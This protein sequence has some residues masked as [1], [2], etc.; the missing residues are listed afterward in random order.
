MTAAQR[1]AINRHNARKSTGPITPEGKER[2]RQN[3]LK[4][5][6]CAA[7]LALPIENADDLQNQFDEWVA[8]YQPVGPAEFAM[9]EEIAHAQLRLRRCRRSE[10]A[11]VELQVNTA[12]RTW[13]DA[14]DDRLSA[15]QQL[16]AVDPAAA[17]RQLR[18]FGPGRRY[19]IDR[20]KRLGRWFLRDGYCG[21]TA[22]VEEAVRLLGADPKRLPAGPPVA[23]EFRVCCTGA[24]PVRDE[25]YLA[26]LLSDAAIH[27][28]Y[29]AEYGRAVPE[30]DDCRDMVRKIVTAQIEALEQEEDDWRADE[31]AEAAGACLRAQVPCDGPDTKLTLRYEAQA[32]GALHKALK[33]L[34]VLQDAR[35]AAESGEP[36]VIALADAP[37]EP[38]PSVARNEPDTPP[39]SPLSADIQTSCDSSTE[40]NPAAVTTATL[41]VEEVAGVVAVATTEIDTTIPPIVTPEMAESP[42]A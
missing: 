40:A 27:P 33:A 17:V 9:V 35:Y 34:D 14:Q 1:R 37:P 32:R 8:S 25:T 18:R 22:L 6:L 31:Q 29:H 4:H 2:A 38:L 39:E 20:W 12:Y 21:T 19:M 15:L 16:L 23:Y 28:E 42:P 7:V 11:V 13:S 30:T 10:G 3:S 24:R 36:D 41:T 26:W 5:G